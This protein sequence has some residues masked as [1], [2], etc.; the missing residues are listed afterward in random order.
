MILA[1]VQSAREL[2][3]YVE[4]N[5]KNIWSPCGIMTSAGTL[6][7]D[8]H[9]LLSRV[10]KCPVLNRYGSREAGDMACSCAKNDGLH[11][12]M[13]AAYLEILDDAGLP[14]KQGD[15]G[16]IVVT[17]LTNYAMPLIR[18]QIGDRGAMS[19]VM[20]SCGRGWPLL[21]SVNGRTVD[22]FLT[23]DG[24]KV[25]GEYFTH[26]FYGEHNVKQFQIV[27]DKLNHLVISLVF[28]DKDNVE[29]Q[30]YMNLKKEIS[31]VMGESIQIE[32]KSVDYIPEEK[33]GKRAYTISLLEETH[34]KN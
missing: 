15:V 16:N 29:E 32:Y 2:A 27:Q 13:N 20:C 23:P 26:L 4:R 11:I 18:Y 9:D 33:S 1:Y 14:C 12:N 3:R 10:F 17:S 30:F 19:G 25:D 21:K 5:G 31:K 8:T 7:R 22:V 6:D 34:E 24:S 28:Y